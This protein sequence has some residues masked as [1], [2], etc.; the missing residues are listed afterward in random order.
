MDALVDNSGQVRFGQFEQSLANINGRDARLRTPMGRPSG[1]FGK[2]FHYKQFQYFGLISDH[3]L[4]GCALADTA[5]LGIAFV[6]F[7]D[8]KKQ[9]LS[10]WTWR[11]PLARQ[12]TLSQSPRE[13]ESVFSQPRSQVHIRMG[14]EEQGDSLVKR[15]SIDT[16]ELTLEAELCEDASFQPMSLCTRT[17][18]NGFTYANKVAGVAASGRLSVAGQDYSLADDHCCGHHDFTA[19]YLR[20]ET[21]WNWACSST[22]INGRRLGFNL[23]CGVNETSFSENCLWLDGRLIPVGGISFD[24]NANQLL[25]DWHIYD[26]EGRIDLHFSAAGRHRERLNVGLFASN[27]QQL[28]GHFHGQLQLDKETLTLEHTPGFVEEQYAKW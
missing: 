20:R 1:A 5:W 13:G 7:Y 22:Q 24:Y 25:D 21:F 12:L 19:G 8:I 23:S 3:Y 27:F 14:Y 10:E 4:L 28:F 26:S 16:P 11:S 15:L 18:I 9:R 2:H 6:Y 17:G